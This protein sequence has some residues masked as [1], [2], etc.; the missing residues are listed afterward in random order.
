M[1]E[2]KR[3]I[4]SD[5]PLHPDTPKTLLTAMPA[6]AGTGSYT[7]TEWVQIP[8]SPCRG[9]ITRRMVFIG[10][11]TGDSREII[12]PCWCFDHSYWQGYGPDPS[13]R[14]HTVILKEVAPGSGE[15]RYWLGQCEHCR[16]IQWSCLDD[17]QNPGLR[18]GHPTI[19]TALRKHVQSF[20]V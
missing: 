4:V 11:T 2:P 18:P 13:E 19:A 20:S 5:K 3:H 1:P 6:S 15:D 7:R 17:G 16:T 12:S 8:C 10:Y 14:L 9:E